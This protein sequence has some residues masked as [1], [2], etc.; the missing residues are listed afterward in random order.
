MNKL[1][2]ALKVSL[3]STFSMYFKAHSYH[4][5][6]E[7]SGFHANHEFLGSIYDD[8][9]GAVDPMAENIRKLDEYAP[10]SLHDILGASMVEEDEHK[11]EEFGSMVANLL[12]ANTIVLKSLES[13]FQLAMDANEQGLV[14]F[15]ADR[16]DMHKKHEWMLKSSIK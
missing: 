11:P 1:A 9:Y 3:G 6:V 2:A 8:L 14:N 10:I 12:T 15:L 4:W 7:G 16:M 13:T 5:N